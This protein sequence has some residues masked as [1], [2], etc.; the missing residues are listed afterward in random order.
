METRKNTTAGVL[1]WTPAPVRTSRTSSV[2][3]EDAWEDEDEDQAEKKDD[4]VSQM[5][6]NG[7]IGLSEALEDVELGE[8]C[9][10]NLYPGPLTTEE[11]ESSGHER[12]TPEELSYNLSQHL[13]HA[14]SPREDVQSPFEDLLE[15]FKART[16]N[17]EVRQRKEEQGTEYV[18]EWDKCLVMPEE[19]KDGEEAGNMSD[20]KRK[21]NNH[22]STPRKLETMNDLTESYISKGEI[23]KISPT[24]SSSVHLLAMEPA[25]VSRHH[26]PIS[27]PASPVTAP[28]FPH[29]LHFTPEEIATAPGI[30]AETLPEISLTESP[31]ASHRSHIPVSVK[32]RYHCPEVQLRASPQPAAIFPEEV[33]SSHYSAVSDGPLKGSEKSDKPH[34]KP[35]PSPRKMRQLSPEAACSRTRSLSTVRADV[36]K[37]KHQTTSPDRESR[38]LRARSD[39]AEVD[40]S[41]KGPLSYPTPDFSKVEPRVRF[42]KGG[43]KPPKSR[44]SSNRES[45]SPE[46]PFVF[47]SPADIV[48]EVLLNTTDGSPASSDSDKTP[49]SALNATVPQEF[50]CRQQAT[51]LLE[52][53]EENYYRLLTEYAEAKNTIDRLRLEAKVNLY[54]DPPK[55]G[56][57]VQS[58]LNQDTSKLMMLNFPQAQRAEINSASP[59]PN[60]H[61]THQGSSPAHSTRSPDPQVGQKLVKILYNQAGKFLQQLQTTEDLLKSKKLKP[62]D[63]I[64]DLSLLSEGLDSLER[65][66][67]LARD[68]HKL[69][70]HQHAAPSHFD[71]ERELEGLIFQCGLRMDEL[72]EQVEQMQQEQPTCEAPPSPSPHP[73]S[74]SIPSEGGETLTC[75]QSPPVPLLV[76]PGEAAAVE[77]SS[78]SEESDEEEE[79]LNSLYLKPLSDKRGHVEQDFAALMDHYQSF[80][81]LPKLLDH[82]QKEGALS[83]ALRGDMRPGDEEKER[84]GKETENLKVQKILPHSKD[85]SYHQDSPHAHTSK[86]HTNRSSPP[87]HR[88]SSPSTTLPLHRPS[89]RKR[90]EVGKSHSSSLSSLGEITALDRRN[91]KLQTGSS[92]VLSQDGIISP[93][94]DSGFVCSESSRLTPAAAPSPLHQRASESISVPQEGNPGN[95]QTGAVSEPSPASSPSQSRTAMEPRRGPRLSHDQPK[96]TRQG[97]RRRTFSCSPQRWA[98]PTEKTAADSGTSEFGLESDSSHTVS[99]EGQ[100]DQYT[101][102]SSSPSSSPARYHHGDSPKALTSSHSATRDDAIQTLQA[103]VTRLRESLESCLRNRKPLSSVRAAPSA[104]E[105]H[106]HHN[107]FTPHIRLGERWPNVSRDIRDRQTVDEVEEAMPR[108]TTRKR[109][110]SAHRQKPQPDILTGSEPSAPQP[111]PLM[112]RSTQTS[113]AAPDSCRSRTNKGHSRTHPRQHT[114]EVSETA[115][116]P[117]SRGRRAPLCAQCLSRR[118]GQ[119]E[120]PAGGDREPSHSSC[121]LHC[122]LCGRS[123][124]CRSTEPDCRRVSDP[125]VHTSCQSDESLDRA[126]RTKYFAAAAPPALLQYMPVCPPP[127]LLFSPPLY[128]SPGN[129]TGTSPGVRG[130]GEVRGRT[131]RSLSADKQ[132]SADSS[133]DSSLNRAIRA[134]RHMKHTSGHMARS[135][136]AGLHYQQLLTQT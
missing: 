16:V 89:S 120:M 14:E 119:S 40:E 70:Q 22:T 100:N 43:Y 36:L 78:A 27:Q 133:M 118:Q 48:K 46:P 33:M 74:S 67:L 77:V 3:S 106:T 71:P 8:S 26:C 86:Q 55:P 84:Q 87:S 17:K 63:L 12:D 44:R 64:K 76:D 32:S 19:E 127:L 105:N 115:D 4:F 101:L 125:P 29:L 60:G 88:A 66:F 107:T 11:A 75:P 28:T 38:T 45:L 35:T 83:A 37:F 39:A 81:E 57:L 85:Q 34:K 94:T 52:Q 47:K 91:S 95:P 134:A 97:Q 122:P 31:P 112:S 111:K 114:V 25:R 124:S 9:N 80:K 90:L 99:K 10:P 6:E 135:L 109:S 104:Q 92:R 82:N 123:E 49:I 21:K 121:C 128:V 96:R 53:L 23:K 18:S 131:R 110:S 42:P 129:S 72:K 136:A 13:S 15:S 58:G 68:E 24:Q 117:D 62:V 59:H 61:S 5:D 50:R 116:E 113:T 65:G 51:V 1:F 130:R 103:E 69:L 73:T 54:S 108:R 98:R 102:H 56:H 2:V 7:I 41:R 93:E 126:A 132:R 20:R 30:D 79:T